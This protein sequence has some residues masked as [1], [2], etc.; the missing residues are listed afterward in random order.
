MQSHVEKQFEKI[1]NSLI[2]E[3]RKRNYTQSEVLEISSSFF[4]AWQ[5]SLKEESELNPVNYQSFIDRFLQ[6]I[7][8]KA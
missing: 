2:E 5:K 1:H 3:L 6:E 4:I 7:D 8:K